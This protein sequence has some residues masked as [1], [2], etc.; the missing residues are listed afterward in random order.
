MKHKHSFSIYQEVIYN[1]ECKSYRTGA[2][3]LHISL[4]AAEQAFSSDMQASAMKLCTRSYLSLVLGSTIKYKETG[5]TSKCGMTGACH[6]VWWRGTDYQTRHQWDGCASELDKWNWATGP[7]KPKINLV[8]TQKMC[9]F[10]AG[11]SHRD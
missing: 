10:S 6:Y 11:W 9:F 2:K 3:S 1:K 7:I 8:L 4:T 5:S